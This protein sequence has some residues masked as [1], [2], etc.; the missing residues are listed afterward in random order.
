MNYVLSTF[1]T[2][3]VDKAGFVLRACHVKCDGGTYFT[4]VSG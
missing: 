4:V 3:T 1:V 2:T